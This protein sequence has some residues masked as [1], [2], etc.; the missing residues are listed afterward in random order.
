MVTNVLMS[1][2]PQYAEAI[3]LGTKRYELR[4]MRPQFPPGTIVWLYATK[5]RGAI[6]GCFESGEIIA[7]A[8]QT[9]WRSIGAQLGIDSK[10]VR[11]YVAGCERVFAIEIRGASPAPSDLP[12]P[13]GLIPPQSYMYL[14]VQV[15]QP[16]LWEGLE[17][18][19]ARR[20]SK[21]VAMTWPK[22]RKMGSS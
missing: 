3:L 10:A 11:A 2:H 18:P 4:R 8:P 19:T 9:L 15:D 14:P 12:I 7:G 20:L 5:P 6:V 21:A 13:A 17:M 16:S 22:M 1:I